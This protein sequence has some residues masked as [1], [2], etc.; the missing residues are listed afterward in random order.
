[1]FGG[2]NRAKLLSTLYYKLK[3]LARKAP[4][5]QYSFDSAA[6]QAVFRGERPTLP[7]ECPADIVEL[8]TQCW[9]ASPDKR[10]SF[11]DILVRIEAFKVCLFNHAQLLIRY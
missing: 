3:V 5:S 8:V 6:I 7:S 1:M 4:F 9:D 11:P 2:F 10:P